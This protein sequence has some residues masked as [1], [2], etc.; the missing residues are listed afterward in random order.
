VKVLSSK[1]YQYLR[2]SV[3]FKKRIIF[4]HVS[5]SQ[6]STPI[7]QQTRQYVQTRRYQLL[8]LIH[9]QPKHLSSVSRSSNQALS[10]QGYGLSGKIFL[11]VKNPG[12]PRHRLY[13]PACGPYGL[14]AEP[15]AQRTRFSRAK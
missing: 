5:S 13:P 1:I 10:Q 4:F 11:K 15:E 12:S 8:F 2:L 14:E 3:I 6:Q 7:P 9:I